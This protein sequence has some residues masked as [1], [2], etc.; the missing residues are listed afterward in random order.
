M[1]RSIIVKVV[2]LLVSIVAYGQIASAQSNTPRFE[3]GGQFSAIRADNSPGS[4]FTLGFRSGN[5]RTDIGGGGR[6][7]VNLSRYLAFESEVNL[8]K[9]KLVLSSPALTLSRTKVEGVFGAKAGIRKDQFGFFAKLRPGFMRFS[10]DTNCPGCDVH[11]NYEF[12]LDAGG[13]VEYYPS[14]RFVVRLDA[15]DT[16]I[17][18][19]EKRAPVEGFAQL[20]QSA[21]VV[22]KFQLSI[23]A[24]VRF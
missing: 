13:V 9:E 22:H 14:R 23:G 5:E 1:Q 2:V 15:G 11:A 4:T 21:T 17:F 6:F 10:R 18:L 12:A 20:F 16:M 19:E 3:A 7:T 8:F 24:A